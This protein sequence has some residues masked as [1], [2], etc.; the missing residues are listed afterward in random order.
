VTTYDA[1]STP[2]TLGRPQYPRW[3]W[4]LGL[5]LLVVIA[6]AVTALVFLDEDSDNDVR[7]AA[8]ERFYP[9]E[10]DKIFQQAPVGLDLAGGFDASLSLNGVAIPEDQLDKTEP[11]NLVLFTPGPG[12]EVE[13]YSQGQNCVVATFWPLSDP[14]VV[15]SRSWCFSVL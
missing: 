11:L 15:A 9:T 1:P 14:S 4:L 10:G 3:L 8:I 6:G 5:G 13:Q 12:K 2:P 7:D